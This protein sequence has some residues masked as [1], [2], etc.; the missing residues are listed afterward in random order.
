MSK[1]AEVDTNKKWCRIWAP[2]S[3]EHLGT[4]L[5]KQVSESGLYPEKHSN[6]GLYPIHLD[7]FAPG[8]PM[9]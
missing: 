7:F 6:F 3:L 5:S 1:M 2:N 8:L 9:V 4:C